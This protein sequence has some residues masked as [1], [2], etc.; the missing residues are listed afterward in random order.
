M[1]GTHLTEAKT[2]LRQL[3]DIQITTCRDTVTVVIGRQKCLYHSAL[4]SALKM[5]GTHLTETKTILGQ[6]KYTWVVDIQLPL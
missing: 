6:L 5:S 4:M 1:S 3:T 2:A